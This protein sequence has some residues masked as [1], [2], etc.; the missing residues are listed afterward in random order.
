MDIQAIILAGG[1]GQRLYPLVDNTPKALLPLANNPM[2]YYQLTLLEK[3][4][5]KECFVVTVE[6]SAVPIS[7]YV[8]EIYRGNIKPT[9][10]T[11]ADGTDS[12][13]ALVHIKDS[14]KSDFLVISCDLVTDFPIQALA[15]QH[16]TENATLSVLLKDDTLHKKS[17][18]QEDVLASTE[19]WGVDEENKRLAY[20]ASSADIEDSFELSA[21]FLRRTPPFTLRTT[22]ADSHLYI[23]SRWVLDLLEK[24]SNM[25]SIKHD[26]VPFLIRLQHR[27]KAQLLKTDVPHYAFDNAQDLAL[28]LSTSQEKQSDFVKCMVHVIPA[29]KGEYCLRASTRQSYTH[30]NNELAT[31][32]VPSYKPESAALPKSNAIKIGAKCVVGE[33]LQPSGKLSVK[34]SIIGKHCSVGEDVKISNSILMDHITIEDKCVIQ[35]SIIS[36]SARIQS[37]TELKDCSVGSSFTVSKGKYKGEMLCRTRE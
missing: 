6:S 11:I 12:A 18:K 10:L 16:L 32:K 5:F 27:K 22:L 25:Q 9:V 4:G 15:R 13:Q 8:N 30:I 1:E 7:K 19:Y 33:G 35:N 20:F 26:L 36:S 37:G 3:A 17:M 23:F 28:S 21:S 29:K 24:K 34:M 31:N 2:I 14:I